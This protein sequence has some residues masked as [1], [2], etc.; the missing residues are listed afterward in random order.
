MPE[1]IAMAVATQVITHALFDNGSTTSTTEAAAQIQQDRADEMFDLWVNYYQPIELVALQDIASRA[2]Y[3][4]KFGATIQRA[5]AQ[6][7][8]Q[9][10][11]SRKKALYCLPPRCEG[12]RRY[13]AAET[14]RAQARV[15]SFA[16]QAAKTAED[17]KAYVKEEQRIHDRM[18][19]N[20]IGLNISSRTDTALAAAAALYASAASRAQAAYASTAAQVGSLAKAGVSQYQGYAR[21]QAQ[22]TA[23]QNA[24]VA[25]SYKY[26]VDASAGGAGLAPVSDSVPIPVM[27]TSAVSDVSSSLDFSSFIG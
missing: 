7:L 23:D 11:D 6:A 10:A 27:D 16:M 24:A 26:N 20:N 25:D 15:V 4:P 17:A 9:A 1:Q 8:Q 13:T 21:D 2:T 5:N 18:L 12:M 14:T 22:I 19:I 3:I